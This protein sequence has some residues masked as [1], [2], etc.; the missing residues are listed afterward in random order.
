[1]GLFQGV[2]SKL[3]EWIWRVGRG[4]ALLLPDD[5]EEGRQL[6][7]LLLHRERIEALLQDERSPGCGEADA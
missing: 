7:F 6:R 2:D 4:I 1:M 5:D 3:Q